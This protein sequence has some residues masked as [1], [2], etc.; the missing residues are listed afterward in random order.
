MAYTLRAL[1]RRRVLATRVARETPVESV[2]MLRR[3]FLVLGLAAALS[4]A[5]CCVDVCDPDCDCCHECCCECDCDCY[6]VCDR[7]GCR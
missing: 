6:C 4:S 3:A 7:C 2:A 5:S 1:L